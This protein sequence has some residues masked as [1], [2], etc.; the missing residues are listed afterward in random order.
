MMT[1]APSPQRT[2]YK[3]AEVCAIAK[4]QPYVL[5]SWEAE[6]PDLGV[7]QSGGRPRVY[8]QTHLDLV[9]RIKALLFSEGLTLGAARRKILK[10]RP[11]DTGDDGPPIEELQGADTQARIDDVKVSLRSIL[12][13]LRTS[14]NGDVATPLEPGVERPAPARLAPARG[15]KAKAT[16]RATKAAGARRRTKV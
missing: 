12:T 6:F 14:G 8:R 9:L 10:E 15:R 7:E 5:R 3:A 11:A 2:L 4:L 13:L 1:P 16:K